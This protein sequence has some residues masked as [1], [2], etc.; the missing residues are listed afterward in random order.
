MVLELLDRISL[1]WGGVEFLVVFSVVG[2]GQLRQIAERMRMLIEASSVQ[3]E[4]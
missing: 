3:R 4:G 1:R 2:F